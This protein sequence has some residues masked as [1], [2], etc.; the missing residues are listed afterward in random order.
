MCQYVYMSKCDM[1]IE[2]AWGTKKLTNIVHCISMLLSW[3]LSCDVDV[4]VNV[5]WFF[6]IFL[7]CRHEL[8]RMQ[9]WRWWRWRLLIFIQ[10]WYFCCHSCASSFFIFSWELAVV[11]GCVIIALTVIRNQQCSHLLTYFHSFAQTSRDLHNQIECNVCILNFRPFL[12]SFATKLMHLLITSRC[13]RFL[14]ISHGLLTKMYN[15][16]TITRWYLWNILNLRCDGESHL[17][18][19]HLLTRLCRLPWC[20]CVINLIKCLAKTKNGLQN[21]KISIVRWWDLVSALFQMK[22][23]L[24]KFTDDKR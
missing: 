4:N 12:S 9:W 23:A 21:N 24:S 20:P 22:L 16:S 7:V 11:T 18:V 14:F 1:G 2:F 15:D 8:R 10:Y 5:N 17:D 13:I 3:R 6:I 19:N